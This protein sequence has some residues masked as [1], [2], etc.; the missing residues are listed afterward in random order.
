M[1][2]SFGKSIKHLLYSCFGD[3][4]S[5]L[6]KEQFSQ[7]W[8]EFSGQILDLVN[9]TAESNGEEASQMIEELEKIG[10]F[11]FIANE[12]QGRG[13]V[14]YSLVLPSGKTAGGVITS[15]SEAEK[16]QISEGMAVDDTFLSKKNM[17]SVI[18]AF[19]SAGS[20]VEKGRV[21]LSE[22]IVEAI[23]KGNAKLEEIVDAN[24]V[25]GV[26]LKKSVATVLVAA[27]LAGGLGFLAGNVNDNGNNNSLPDDPKDKIVN[28]EGVGTLDKDT[29]DTPLPPIVEPIDKSREMAEDLLSDLGEMTEEIGGIAKDIRGATLEGFQESFLL[30]GSRKYASEA[31]R[32]AAEDEYSAALAERDELLGQISDLKEQF[33]NHLIDEHTFYTLLTE[34]SVDVHEASRDMAEIYIDAL[35]T[36]MAATSEHLGVY[37][38]NGWDPTT[39][40][41]QIYEM[42]KDVKKYTAQSDFHGN[43]IEVGKRVL[44]K[45][46]ELEPGEKFD[47]AELV[48]E[49]KA[50]IS[51]EKAEKDSEA[52]TSSAGG[53][54]EQDE[55]VSESEDGMGM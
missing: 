10:G 51:A 8:Q 34:L 44:E 23:Q 36:T 24:M 45:L 15:R 32:I 20:A 27:V 35:N 50:E 37:K 49:A 54:S 5:V 11:K 2:K 4:L 46:E 47:Y 7:V 29:P 42:D 30:S 21:S 18:S 14:H 38:A 31:E 16:G 13:G 41:E 53:I 43:E 17:L 28:T 48:E 33:E 25:W 39:H 1:A 26:N 52:E 55:N 22:N 3:E 12:T 9:T 6:D 19:E 40:E